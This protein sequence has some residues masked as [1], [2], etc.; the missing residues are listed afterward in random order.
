VSLEV[1]DDG[2]GLDPAAVERPPLAGRIGLASCA[3]RVEALEGRFEIRSSV[4]RGT[5]VRAIL[6]VAA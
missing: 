3:E 1:S 6:P 4:A 2:R 5:R